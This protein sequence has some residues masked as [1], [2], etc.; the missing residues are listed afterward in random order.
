MRAGSI[1]APEWTHE[2]S[3][4]AHR[5]VEDVRESLAP[6]R[7]DHAAALAADVQTDK[8]GDFDF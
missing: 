6:S 7:P 8:P 5:L 1:E 3:R 2:D 4:A